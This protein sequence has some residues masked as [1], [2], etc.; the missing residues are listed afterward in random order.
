MKLPS[1]QWVV[2][3][4]LAAFFALCACTKTTG[5]ASGPNGSAQPNASVPSGKVETAILAGGCFW[6]MEEILRSVPGVVSTD[7][8]YTGGTSKDPSYDQVHT[9]TTGH[10]E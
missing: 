1:A 9:G 6:G 3:L 5:D 4:L 7:V 8:G 10:A 2:A